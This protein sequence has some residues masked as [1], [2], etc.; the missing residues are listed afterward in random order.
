VITFEKNNY[1]KSVYVVTENNGK[2]INKPFTNNRAVVCLQPCKILKASTKA[3]CDFFGKDERK[4]ATYVVF[5][6]FCRK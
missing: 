1:L 6:H 3:I 4:T 2:K 5:L